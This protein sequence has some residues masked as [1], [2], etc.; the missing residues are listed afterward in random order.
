MKKIAFTVVYAA[1]VMCFISCSVE[2]HILANN[3][4]S[5]RQIIQGDSVIKDL[6]RIRNNIEQNVQST[7]PSD[8][9][10]S[11][12]IN[13]DDFYFGNIIG[14]EVLAQKNDWIKIKIKEEIIV[15]NSKLILKERV[16][17][18]LFHTPTYIYPVPSENTIKIMDSMETVQQ[19]KL[20]KSEPI[21]PAPKLLT[22]DK[23]DALDQKSL[24]ILLAA[25]SMNFD[26]FR[27]DNKRFDYANLSVGSFRGTFF[28]NC[29]LSYTRC[30]REILTKETDF[31]NAKF[32]LGTHLNVEYAFWK[33]KDVNFSKLTIENSNFENC[34][35]NSTNSTKLFQNAILKKTTFSNTV[36]GMFSAIKFGDTKFESCKFIDVKMYG[37]I[38]H[39]T[40]YIS[41]SFFGGTWYGLGFNS[42]QAPSKILGGSF[43]NLTIIGGDY[44]FINILPFGTAPSFSSVTVVNANFYK[45][46]ISAIMQ[47]GCKFYGGGN[48]SNID[49]ST[50][51][52]TNCEFGAANQAV[53]F[54]MTNS[55]FENTSTMYNVKFIK[56]DLTGSTWPT[57]T[58]KI[59]FID[60]KG[61]KLN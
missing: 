8:I 32:E 26:G 5:E 22:S 21:F 51:F 56:C 52:I 38:N 4:I 42:T 59:E 23:S 31:E 49:F 29:N 25:K 6:S 61:V 44:P 43:N 11:N 50:S 3:E 20:Q 24:D 27:F 10:V 60:C 57:D 55:K 18:F 48:F 47:D 13:I 28:N 53:L 2:K 17:W 7:Y 34:L 36:D 33:F 45:A 40:E 37:I 15:P 54:N 14:E 58:S 39:N 16:G 46:T 9:E 41:C 35:F 19:E 1:T 30:K 12:R